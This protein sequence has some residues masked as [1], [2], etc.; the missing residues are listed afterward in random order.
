MLGVVSVRV[1]AASPFSR[2][3][4]RCMSHEMSSIDRRSFLIESAALA[5]T[6]VLAGCAGAKAAGAGAADAASLATPPLAPPPGWDAFAYNVARGRAGFIP[7]KY[8][9]DIVAPEG[10]KKHLGKHLPYV[11]ALPE[12]RRVDGYLPLMWGDPSKGNAKHP[13]APIDATNPEGHWYNWIRLA[14]V[15]QAE[16]EVETRYDAWPEPTSAVN[17][18]LTG[19]A[20][21]D[22]RDDAGKNT[23]YLAV[24]PKGAKAGDTLR[25]WAHCLTHGEYVDFVTLA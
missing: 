21:A 2:G 4:K 5:A 11:P 23:V 1:K 17:G 13:N 8:L 24:L 19:L 9:A 7:E 14:I 15:G 12:E 6:S 16:G 20:S 22:P 18:K 25:V 3:F 10:D